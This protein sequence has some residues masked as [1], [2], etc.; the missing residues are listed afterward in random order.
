MCATGC[1]LSAHE[2]RSIN[3]EEET[4][5]ANGLLKLFKIR[6]YVSKLTLTV[7]DQ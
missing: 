7:A 2:P 3:N 1:F 4:S 5:E 6:I